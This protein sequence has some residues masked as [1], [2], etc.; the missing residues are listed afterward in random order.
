MFNNNYIL[1]KRKNIVDRINKLNNINNLDLQNNNCFKKIFKLICQKK[2]NYI[3][4]SSGIIFNI[5][6]IDENTLIL[7]DY[8]LKKYENKID[9]I[10]I[11][12]NNKINEN[13][14]KN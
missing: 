9:E 3:V 5:L 10:K 6:D 8:I 14:I 12:F 4:N 13:K 11:D 2:Y 7:I 1:E